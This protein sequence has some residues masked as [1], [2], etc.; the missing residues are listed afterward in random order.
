MHFLF[1]FVMVNYRKYILKGDTFM[2]YTDEHLREISFPLG[3]IG[4]GSIGLAG[5]GRLIDWEIWNLPAKGSSNGYTHFAVKAIKNGKP[6][7]RILNGDLEKDLIGQYRKQPYAGYG[8]G[9]ASQTMCGYPHFRTVEFNGEFPIATLR[10]SDGDFPAD[11]N[12]T[13]FNPFIPG[14]SDLSSIP[15]AFFE[16]ELTNNDSEALEYQVAFSVCNPFV[17]SH[18]AAETENGLHLLTLSNGGVPKDDI[19]YGDLTVAT[20]AETVY[21]QTYWY[22]GNWQDGITSYWNDF[23][24]VEPLK[25]RLYDTDGR[26]DH[27]TLVAAV[28][29]APGESKRVRFV[30]SWNAPNC[31]NYWSEC[32]DE[33]GK[34]V[35]WKNYYAT[36]YKNSAESAVFSLKNWDDLYR[37]TLRFKDTLHGSTLPKEI[38]D[39]AASN[40]SVLKS[41]TVLRLEDGSFYG[42][43]G[44]H[45][46]GGSCEGTCQHVWN[47]AYALC[48]LFPDLERSIRD[49]EFRYATDPNGHMGFRLMLP[50]GR[51]VWNFRSCL[52]GQMGTVIKTYREWKLSG[53]TEWLRSHWETVK[54][55]LEYAWS[56]ENPDAWDA[57]KDGVLEGRQHHTLD[58][59]LFGPSSWLE[60]MYLAALKAASEMADFLGEPDKAKEYVE[61]FEKG[62]AWTK[63]NLFNGR[64]FVQKVDLTDKS[65]AERFGSTDF[66]WNDETGELKYQIGDGSSIDQMLGQWHADILGLGD[67]FDEKQIDTALDEMMKNNFKPS[68]RSVANTWRVFSLNDEAGSVI[69]VYPEGSEKPKIPIPYCEETMTG[70]EYA[71]AGLMFSR[72][73][74]ENGVRIA[75]A[76]R[77]RFNGKNR[78]PWNEIECGNNYA[79]SMASYAFVPILSGF[80]FDLPHRYIG[81]K[82]YT[83][84][85]FAS[86]WSVDGA[87]GDFRT[88]TDGALLTVE[89]GSLTLEAFGVSFLD[90][91]SAV[92]VDGKPIT[93][94]F[95]NGV[96]H[97]EA[98]SDFGTLTI[99]R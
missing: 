41:P 84:D 48:F 64:Y 95:E 9:P 26:E 13:A 47:Y 70:F 85:D 73:K 36:L 97:F 46:T 94:T 71:L 83:T 15:A 29:L 52:D 86:I 7:T 49:L 11:V 78:N 45:E 32:K 63:E 72:G 66:F 50:V 10:F 68:M 1:V 80:S 96:L 54:K 60:G 24:S 6:V 81:F 30:L 93:F 88:N 43:E 91:V 89:E 76:V 56:P 21:T 37:R 53:N 22:R 90:S 55:V 4:S 5:N 12:L 44:V 65:L 20:D 35:T 99:R 17:V 19:A 61:L 40:L 98:Q 25:E 14:E 2:K 3:G 39:A 87:W 16:I 38:I 77:D 59:E 18:N 23:N 28:T 74:T 42:W 75:A 69:C 82:P 79:R 92:L 57:D 67:L 58:T 51:G 34:H 27:A 8:Y 31:Y 62:K 33:N